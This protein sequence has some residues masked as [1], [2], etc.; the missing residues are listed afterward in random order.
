MNTFYLHIKH[1]LYT[2]LYTAIPS[3]HIR[4]PSLVCKLYLP[5][6]CA[7]PLITDVALKTIQLI[8]TGYPVCSNGVVQQRTQLRV[9]G[10]HPTTWCYAVS[11]VVELIWPQLIKIIE[12]TLL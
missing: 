2:E 4:Q 10:S 3:D 1:T 7:K 5:P 11:L 6:F 9:T 12:Q 8:K